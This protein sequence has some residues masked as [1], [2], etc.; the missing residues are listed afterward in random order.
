MAKAKEAGK[1]KELAM[2]KDKT[3]VPRVTAIV[4]KSGPVAIGANE[5]VYKTGNAYCIFDR[6]EGGSGLHGFP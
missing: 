3:L 2:P 1:A 5:V 6:T 4:R